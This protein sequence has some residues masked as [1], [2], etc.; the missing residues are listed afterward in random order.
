MLVNLKWVL[1]AQQ[2]VHDLDERACRMCIACLKPS[3]TSDA[4]YISEL[5]EL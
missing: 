2:V 1:V 5:H 4:W 3:S